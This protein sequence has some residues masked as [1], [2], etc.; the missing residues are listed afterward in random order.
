[1]LGNVLKVRIGRQQYELMADTQLSDQSVD[2]ACVNPALA[3]AIAELG[4]GDMIFTVRNKERK[5]S[6]V[7]DDVNSGFR[8]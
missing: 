2:R 5:R 8:T 7:L 1:M 4:C 3:A 6:E